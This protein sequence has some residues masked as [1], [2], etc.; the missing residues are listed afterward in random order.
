[1]DVHQPRH[2]HHAGAVDH[3][4][5]GAGVA[6]ADK[7]Q[8]A[9]VERDVGVGHVDM[10]FAAGIPGDHHVGVADESCHYTYVTTPSP[11]GRGL[12]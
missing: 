8:R 12:G 5:R 6:A 1:M 3:G 2:D 9:A 4:F 10:R 7:R 11:P